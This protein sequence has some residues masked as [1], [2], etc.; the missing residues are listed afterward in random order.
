MPLGVHF[1]LETIAANDS[2]LSAQSIEGISTLI[3]NAFY[4]CALP[5]SGDPLSRYPVIHIMRPCST[6]FP[7]DMGKCLLR[8][9]R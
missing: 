1:L 6:V 9:K 3:P 5:S 2:S 8:F 4:D 7:L